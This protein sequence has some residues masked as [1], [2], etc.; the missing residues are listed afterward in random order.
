MHEHEREKRI[1]IIIMGAT[2][3][4]WEG[5]SAM[6]LGI[7]G[8]KNAAQKDEE[9][10]TKTRNQS[11]EKV[12]TH[13]GLARIQAA[14]SASGRNDD[15]DDDDA[16]A[17]AAR[18]RGG[19]TSEEEGSA[20][21][22]G[23]G[24]GG[25]FARNVRWPTD[26]TGTAARKQ[27]RKYREQKLLSAGGVMLSIRQKGDESTTPQE[28][29]LVMLEYRMKANEEQTP[30]LRATSEGVPEMFIYGSGTM[31]RGWEIALDTCSPG[32]M[33]VTKIAPGLAFDDEDYRGNPP[34]PG[35]S[36]NDVIIAEITLVAI[37]PKHTV[38]VVPL[39]NAGDGDNKGN[40]T[41]A[42]FK[43]ITTKGDGW[44]T[45]RT[46]YAASVQMHA[47]YVP[48]KVG[49]VVE[50]LGDGGIVNYTMGSSCSVSHQ[51]RGRIGAADASD[52]CNGCDDTSGGDG[53]GSGEIPVM[54]DCVEKTIAT[55]LIGERCV[56]HV[57]DPSLIHPSFTI[58][59]LPRN[60]AGVEID[61]HLHG[62]VQVRDI[63]GDGLC[64][65]TRFKEGRGE[66]PVDCPLEDCDITYGLIGKL[67]EGSVDARGSR[68][69]DD[70]DGEIFVNTYESGA[71]LSAT[72]G[73]SPLPRGLDTCLRLMTEG[74]V[75][76]VV[77]APQYAY[78]D[79][80][81][82]CKK[83]RELHSVPVTCDTD[84]HVM[85]QVELI[86]W[87]RQRAEW[88]QLKFNEALASATRTR[89]Q[90][91]QHFR[92]G[93]LPAAKTKYEAALRQLK[94]LMTEC[95]TDGEDSVD[96]SLV[97]KPLALCLINL[98]AVAQREGESTRS[99]AFC[100]DAIEAD[101]TCAKAYYRRGMA[102][103]A[104]ESWD[105]A[106]ADFV[107]MAEQDPELA[108]ER[109]SCLAKM[110]RKKQELAAA[111]KRQAKKMMTTGDAS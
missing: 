55:M 64:M 38:A 90:G 104:R 78:N 99:I 102:Y 67:V 25:G 44:E 63:F 36:V 91:N 72:L 42:L 62:F 84:N 61:I 11:E 32:A 89:E 9:E 73:M 29:D 76:N 101:A 28:G 20:N 56:L 68:D 3:A 75:S 81:V 54:L 87:K 49:S 12:Y 40:E 37:H 22:N 60:S 98:A 93:K 7:R 19:R 15:G 24:C 2:N 4:L 82:D 80:K 48:L 52:C 34:P 97:L 53:T 5:M 35:A 110:D 14:M 106:R 43:V 83:L 105:E 6:M 109:D 13:S 45:P 108:G 23:A 26:Q 85:W 39:T 1:I 107:A 94:R 111:E 27:F 57:A 17:A 21:R 77:C 86:S 16:A 30:I 79:Q 96:T 33:L 69:W 18:R 50:C 103:M 46:P 59:G 88:D 92:D 8:G 58:P 70:V 51:S 41:P 66:F 47:K 65:K 31:L 95:E 74:E 10:R 100:S 71:P